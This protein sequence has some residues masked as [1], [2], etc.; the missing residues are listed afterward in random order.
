MKGHIHSFETFG[1]KDGPGIRFV[2][3][4][5]GCPLRCLY[6]HNPDTWKPNEA[7]YEL[8]PQQALDEVMK[9]KAFVKGGVTVSGG[10]PMMQPE[11][12]LELFKLCKTA[13]IH[14]A[15]DTSGFLFNDKTKEVLSYTDLVLLDI[16]HINPNKYKEL[17][18]RPLE[19]TLNFIEYL[20][21]V[22]KPVWLRYVLVP[23]FTDNEDDLHRWAQYVSQFKN[24]ER[25]DI[26][27]FH[28]MGIHKWEQI[29][30]EYKLKDINSPSNQELNKA[31]AI[32]KS[33]GLNV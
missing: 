13:G 1:T 18:A 16:K 26:L 27:P 3:F 7:K 10:E 2:F 14:T 8:T 15:I 25:V 6:C 23:H 11:F 24:V 32:F 29:G 28:Q 4:M 9:V 12:V 19:P 17:T 30:Q 33:Y 20:A 5:Q 21:E 22:N 31:E